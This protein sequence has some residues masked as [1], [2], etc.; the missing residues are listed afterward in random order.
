MN[1]GALATLIYTL[2]FQFKGLHI[3]AT[4]F[5]II[6]I[7][8]FI[9]FTLLFITRFLMFGKEAYH[10]IVDNMSSLTLLACLPIGFVTLPPNIALTVSTVPWGGYNWTLLA[11]V[12]WW[13]ATIWILVTLFFVFITLIRRH[14]ATD[15]RLPTS[16]I[17]P[18]VSVATAAVTGALITMHGESMTPRL[19]IPVIIASFLLTGIGLIMAIFLFT[20]L[21]HQLLT[22]NWPPAAETASM[23][24]FIGPMGQCAAALQLLGSSAHTYGNFAG[25]NK[26]TFLTA[27]TAAP[28]DAACVLLAMLLTGM[29]FVW[30]IFSI[31]AMLER[32]CQGTLKWSPGWNSL[33]FPTATLTTSCSQF[34][35]EMDSPAWRVITTILV[36]SM[37]IIYLVN[38]VGT[39]WKVSKGELLIVREDP[40]VKKRMEEREKAK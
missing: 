4:I 18:A 29:G 23:F 11:Y 9:L 40:R 31:Y 1:S 35:I 3:I 24:I 6:D 7:I 21:F 28:L 13:I 38:V 2:P 33:I 12:L 25:Y 26:G 27:E 36:V 34:A 22:Q 20:Y 30:L 39:V 32:A 14:E 16:I 19:A 10:E 5:F 8:L 15:Q 17:L 37:V